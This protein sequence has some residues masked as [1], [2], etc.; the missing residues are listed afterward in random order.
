MGVR[1]SERRTTDARGTASDCDRTDI[2]EFRADFEAMMRVV[3]WAVALNFL[4]GI[5][6][7]RVGLVVMHEPAIFAVVT[8]LQLVSMAAV[9]LARRVTRPL[10]LYFGA[11]LLNVGLVSIAIHYLGGIHFMPG[12]LLYTL[13]VANG[14]IAGYAPAHALALAS[15]VSYAGL[16]ALELS[17]TWPSYVEPSIPITTV[18]ARAW[19]A[20]IAI[21]AAVLHVAAAYAGR[22]AGLL[23]SRRR[24]LE[25]HRLLVEGEMKGRLLALDAAEHARSENDALRQRSE[26]YRD[27]VHVVVHNLKNPV[28][29][30]YLTADLLLTR[31]RAELGD[32]AAAVGRI[33]EMAEG[34]EAQIF[35]LI[36]LF[37]V[38]S[39]PEQR[40]WVDLNRLARNALSDL[41][42][43]VENKEISVEI[44][45]LPTIWGEQ[46]KLGHALGNLLS[47]AV[48]YVPAKLGRV[49]VSGDVRDGCA[50]V[51]VEDNGVGI[52]A[53]YQER[54]FELFARVPDD[55]QRVDG[56]L[57]RG[58]GVGLA[59]VRRIIESHHGTI[60]VESEPA[61]GARFEVR[62]P[63]VTELAH[64]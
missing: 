13:I 14:G 3:W 12:A 19:P 40:S 62:L 35:A 39:T 38:V 1:N 53:V 57:V 37:R 51:A 8:A 22:M 61:H 16:V 15:W 55:G 9:W 43:I 31:R 50:T 18:D 46:D 58:T 28:N 20:L 21:V 60:S 33:R 2:D 4:I 17:G 30:I 59:L 41:R 24:Q 54:I 32:T 26:R 36:N 25:R 45:P 64:A 56:R 42:V 34:L 44:G 47:N 23:R 29:A 49:R 6:A 27:F 63:M 52:P 11:H 48:N 7:H 5:V 10:A